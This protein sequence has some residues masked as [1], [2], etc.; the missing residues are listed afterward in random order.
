[1]DEGASEKERV[2]GVFDR[3]S[4]TYDQ[5]G[6]EFFGTVAAEL[7]RC[8]VPR[9]GESVL[10][11]GSGRG[12]SVLP[13]A[14]AVGPRGRVLATDLAPGM[15]AAL[16]DLTSDLPWVE[17]REGDA[18]HPPAGPWD[19]VHAGLVLFFLPDL[20]G[21]L[22][23]V[24]DVLAPRGRFGFTWFGESDDSWRGVTEQMQAL[25]PGPT[26]RDGD[27]GES[28]PPGPFSS[29]DAMHVALADH[30]FREPTTTTIRVQVDFADAGQWW[31]WI[32]SA[33]L[34]ALLERLEAHGVLDRARA[35]VD[36]ELE[37]RAAEGTLSWWTDVR[38]TVTTR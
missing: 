16:R 2:A 1:M 25:L 9:P 38:C 36:P 13:S 32:W 11:L 18:E 26:D 6:V 14:R 22:D 35:T 3:A 15:L 24:R 8:T 34:R 20:H 31:A 7:V 23:R 27:E 30:G 19:V 29:I 10:E 28:E 17:V 5:V 12:A 21:T 4:A 33:G 37:R